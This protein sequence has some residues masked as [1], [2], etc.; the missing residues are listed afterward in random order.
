MK[1]TCASGFIFCMMKSEAVRF[2]ETFFV[3]LLPFYKQT[4]REGK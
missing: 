4:R 2:I 1:F 3:S